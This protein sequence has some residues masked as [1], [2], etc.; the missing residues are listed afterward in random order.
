MG[1]SPT[2]ADSNLRNRFNTC[3]KAA[4]DTGYTFR[5]DSV[6]SD[7]A[8]WDVTKVTKTRVSGKRLCAFPNTPVEVAALLNTSD[9]GD[10]SAKD[11]RDGETARFLLVKTLPPIIAR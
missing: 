4:F 6:P 9:F 2:S 8:G 7:W 10:Q 1:M 11:C 5:V 3:A